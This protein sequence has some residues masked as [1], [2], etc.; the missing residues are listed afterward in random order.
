MDILGN[1]VFKTFSQQY[2][3]FVNTLTFSPLVLIIQFSLENSLVHGL[4]KHPV[5]MFTVSGL[6]Q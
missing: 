3:S 4:G 1:Y 6:G 5:E 2:L